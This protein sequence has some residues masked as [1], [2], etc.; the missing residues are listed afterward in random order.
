MK[1]RCVPAH[2]RFLEI[3]SVWTSVCMCVSA[4]EAISMIWIPYNW[5]NKGYSFYMAAVVII[6]GGRG[7]RI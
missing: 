7:L 4:P 2:T 5:L 6:S 3:V 1:I